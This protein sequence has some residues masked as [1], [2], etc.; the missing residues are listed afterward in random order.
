MSVEVIHGLPEQF[1]DLEDFRE[2]SVHLSLAVPTKLMDPSKITFHRDPRKY[3]GNKWNR[4]VPMAC[5]CSTYACYIGAAEDALER[6]YGDFDMEQQPENDFIL[7]LFCGKCAKQISK[8]FSAWKICRW[9]GG[10][11]W[12]A[13]NSSESFQ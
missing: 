3:Y 2:P 8:P 12:I 6:K 4:E 5:G 1:S 9:H 11:N 10:A 7:T 13:Q